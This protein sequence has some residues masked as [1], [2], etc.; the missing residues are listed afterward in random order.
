MQADYLA[1]Q[2][3]CGAAALTLTGPLRIGLTG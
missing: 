1:L 3:S 2:Y